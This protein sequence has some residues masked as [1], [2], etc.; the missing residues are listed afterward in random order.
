[1]KTR[2][3][4]LFKLTYIVDFPV[5]FLFIGVFL[6]IV[7]TSLFVVLDAGREANVVLGNLI[8]ISIWFIPVYLLSSN[9]IFVPL[10]SEVLRKTLSYTFGVV[11]C[12]LA[13]NNF[14]LI[15]Y[16]NAF[17]VDTLG[18]NTVLVLHFLFGLSMF[19]YFVREEKLNQ[20]EIKST[21]F[22]LVLYLLFLGLIQAIYFALPRMIS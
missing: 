9:A 6:D 7:S 18:F 1:V 4:Q 13:L 12:L 8:S 21:V 14:S 15:L 2:R 22:K 5:V 11:H 17:V 20:K 3:F 10:L 19:V 16:N